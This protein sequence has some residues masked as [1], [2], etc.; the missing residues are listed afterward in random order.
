MGGLA[1]TPEHGAQKPF[2]GGVGL[3]ATDWAERQQLA[4]CTINPLNYTTNRL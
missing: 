1:F 3:A 4:N 2:S